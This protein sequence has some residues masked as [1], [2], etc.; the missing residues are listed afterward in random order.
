MRFGKPVERAGHPAFC[1]LYMS[2]T[3]LDR[4]TGVSF[5]LSGY[6]LWEG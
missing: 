2:N 3:F 4:T 1:Q 6:F 5:E